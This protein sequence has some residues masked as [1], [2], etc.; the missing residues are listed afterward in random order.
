MRPR[1]RAPVRPAHRTAA[2]RTRTRPAAGGPGARHVLPPHRASSSAWFRRYVVV[3]LEYLPEVAL[4][5]GKAFPSRLAP[6]CTERARR[7]RP[8]IERHIDVV[9]S[10]GRRRA[11]TRL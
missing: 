10:D 11:S 9:Q 6:D 1:N 3:V 8:L 7:P 5:A 4:S 2:D